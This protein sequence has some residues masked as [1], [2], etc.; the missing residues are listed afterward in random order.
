M[1]TDL[2]KRMEAALPEAPG[3]GYALTKCPCHGEDLDNTL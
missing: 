3:D 1:M 2:A